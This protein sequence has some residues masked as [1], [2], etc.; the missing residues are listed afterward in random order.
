[1]VENTKQKTD[2]KVE[3]SLAIHMTDRKGLIFLKYYMNILRR[4]KQTLQ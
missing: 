1:M 3:K 2:N 4:Y